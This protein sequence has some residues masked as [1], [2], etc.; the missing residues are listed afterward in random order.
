MKT[1]SHFKK[2]ETYF[3]HFEKTMLNIWIR[4]KRRIFVTQTQS[5]KISS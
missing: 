5:C 2:V 1:V 3:T 4:E